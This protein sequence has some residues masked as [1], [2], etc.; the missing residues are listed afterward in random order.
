MQPRQMRET[1][2]PVLPRRRYSMCFLAR[3]CVA[4][5]AGG[6]PRALTVARRPTA[7]NRRGAR[8]GAAASRAPCGG[9][10]SR[11]FAAAVLGQAVDLGADVRGLRRRVRERE[12]PAERDARL[13]VASEL[14]QQRSA[15]AE[16]VEVARQIPGERLDE[17]ERRSRTLATATARLSVMTGEGCMRSSTA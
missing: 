12:R 15:N 1:V 5:R 8:P 2:R 9:P 7:S 6:K 11:A 4:V 16:E 10:G 13:V 14:E 3:V 17:L